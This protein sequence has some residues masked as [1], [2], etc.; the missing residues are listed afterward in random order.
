M[1]EVGRFRIKRGAADE[2]L[3]LLDG[4]PDYDR[5]F[6]RNV[7]RWTIDLPYRGSAFGRGSGKH[8]QRKGRPANHSDG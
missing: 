8:H 3:H 6:F 2:M 5:A 1:A 4:I 7:D